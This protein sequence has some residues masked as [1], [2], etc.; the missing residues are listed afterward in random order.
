MSD[1]NDSWAH[2]RLPIGAALVMIMLQL[3][4]VGCAQSTAAQPSVAQAQPGTSKAIVPKRYNVLF[5][6]SDDLRAE[7]G[8]YGG[9]AKTPNLDALAAKSVRFDRAYCQYPLCNPSRSSFLTGRY[10][11]STGIFG[12]RENFRTAHPDWVSLPQFFKDNGYA[13]LRAGKVFHGA[14]GL[15]DPKAWTEGYESAEQPEVLSRR[16]RVIYASQSAPS[17]APPGTRLTPQE[18]AAHRSDPADRNLTQGQRSD[19]WLVLDE[20]GGRSGENRHAET[21]IG[22]LQRYKDKPFFIACGFSK[23]HSP[24]AAP[25]KYY[26][27]YDIDRI[28]LPPDYAV[29]PTVWPGFPQGSIRPRNS[30]LFMGRDST[31]Q[32]AREMIR[33]Y[34]ASTSWMD[35]NVGR[36]LAELDK[37]GLRQNTIVVFTS[38]HGYQLGEKGKWSKAGSVWEQGSRVPLIIHVP[39]GGGNGKVTARTVE[40]IDLYPTLAEL[41]RL[42]ATSELQGQSMVPLLNHPAAPW[43]HP[44][45]TVWSE[46]GRTV[47]AN[48]VR[49]ERW[50]YAEFTTGG[51][52]AMLLDEQADP[53][54]MKNLADDP[55]H[56]SVRAEMSALLK[57]INKQ[58]TT[59]PVR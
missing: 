53:H 24:P 58:A 57:S 26:E 4:M 28:A 32:T 43:N 19:R 16:Q 13:S 2:H 20:D 23:P 25:L 33:A 12:N 40:L 39:D 10:P 46:D 36:V 48:A 29:R 49:T 15:D 3:V 1:A 14:A 52:G 5:L 54:E 50:R 41:C 37:L 35:W 47:T 38:D 17:A 51:G 44:A 27:M 34:L 30:D 55:R 45:Y 42:Q 31:S 6:I 9:L 22:Y 7:L 21:T 18:I 11:T 56:A 8:S 59:A